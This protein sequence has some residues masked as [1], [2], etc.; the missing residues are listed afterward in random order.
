[1]SS[2]RPESG[3]IQQAGW[4][5][6]TLEPAEPD[7]DPD[8]ESSPTLEDRLSELED[9]WKEFQESQEAD[10]APEILK[11]P[12]I[13]IGGRIHLDSWTFADDSEGIHFFENPGTGIDPEN[14][15][16]FRRVRLEIEGEVP[17]N[18]VYRWQIDFN[19]PDLPQYK[20]MYLGWADLPYLQTLLI[21][22]QKRPLGLDHWNSS[23]YNIF[24][25]RP[26]VIEAFNQDARRLGVQSYGV[27]DDLAY[28]WQYGVFLLEDLQSTGTVVG[29]TW[30]SSL[31]AR[32]TSS[33][34]Y[35]ECSGGR[36]YLHLGIAGML[37]FPEGDADPLDSNV[38]E[39]RFQTRTEERSD[40]RWLNT[41]RI[42]GAETYEILGLETILNVGPW[43]FVSEYQSTW[44][45]RDATT[46]GTGPDLFFH[47]AYAY[48]AWMLTGEQMSYD[49]ERSQLG[50]IRP[51]EN[52]FLVRTCDDDCGR[53]WGAWQVALRYSYLD[54]T[55]QDI[56]GGIGNDVTLALVWYWS[57]F[58][59]MQF[60]AVY[61][62]VRDHEPVQGFTD[63]HF[64]ALGTRLRIEF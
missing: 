36:G 50:R 43:Q 22:N 5:E 23:R 15:I 64:T 44:T 26:L 18:M 3:S 56:R 35:D 51:F 52:F 14:R 7:P 62:D 4:T 40:Q 25:E 55:D 8:Q 21:G 31:N 48:L 30:Q 41:G 34:W 63:G 47:G 45:Q 19:N 11:E 57:A 10:E 27:S 54:L 1:V 58:A 32:L 29:D 13:E 61:G 17:I 37:A 33:P 16:F 39:A 60:N 49:R 53:G 28:T 6:P 46:P 42:A 9:Q 2:R 38:N 20:D 12:T 59:S 24:M